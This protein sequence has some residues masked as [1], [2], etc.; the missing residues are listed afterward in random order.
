MLEACLALYRALGNTTYTAWCLEGI[1]AV[2]GAEQRYARAT[3][4]LAAAA[5]LRAAAQTPRPL[6]EQEEVDTLVMTARAALDEQF[7]S[8]EWRIGSTMAQDDM[9]AD[10]LVDLA[11]WP[12]APIE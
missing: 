9:V 11:T 12:S 7:F 8:E 6:I 4:L 3:R 10:T 5:A 2:A 1:A